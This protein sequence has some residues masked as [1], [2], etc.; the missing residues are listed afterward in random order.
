MRMRMNS[1]MKSVA[2]CVL[3]VVASVRATGEVGPWV[4]YPSEGIISNGVGA[5][6]GWRLRV[7]VEDAARRQLAIGANAVDSAY[8]FNE[9]G[10]ICGTETLDL[11]ERITTSEGERWTIV[12]LGSGYPFGNEDTSPKT[13]PIRYF[14]APRELQ[15]LGGTQ[16]FN[17]LPLPSGEKVQLASFDCPVLSSDAVAYFFN[18]DKLDEA[19]LNVPSLTELKERFL[20]GQGINLG[21]SDFSHVKTIGSYQGGWQPLRPSTISTPQD[22]SFP[23]VETIADSAFTSGCFNKISLGINGNTLKSIGSS[24][25]AIGIGWPQSLN[26]VVLGLAEGCTIGAG[27]FATSDWCYLKTVAFL[28]AVPELA[29]GE[30]FGRP[31]QYA[32][33]GVT[34]KKDYALTM[35]F[36]IPPTA[37]WNGVRAAARALTEEESAAFAERFPGTRAPDGVVPASVFHT[38]TDQ[39]LLTLTEEEVCARTGV[40]LTLSAHGP[41]DITVNGAPGA[42]DFV[43]ETSRVYPYGTTATLVATP[44]R[45][46]FIGWEVLPPGATVDGVTVQATLTA[47]AVARAAFATD[48]VFDSAAKT[49]TDG[50]WVLKVKSADAAA[51]TLTLDENAVSLAPGALTDGV[52]DLRGRITDVATGASWTLN[53]FSFGSFK[54]ANSIIHF[55]APTALKSWPGQLFNGVKSLKTLVVRAPELTGDFGRWSWSFFYSSLE[56][57]VLDVPKMTAF[58]PNSQFVNSPLTATDLAEWNLSSVKTIG[59]NDDGSKGALQIAGP[60]PSGTLKLPALQTAGSNAFKNWSRLEKIELGTDGNLVRVGATA[61]ANCA[62]LRTIDFGT[63]TSF[64]CD[65]NAFMLDD[66]TPLNVAEFIWQGA[67]VPPHDTVE[68]VLQGRTAGDNPSDKPVVIRVD[69]EARA[70]GRLI[71]PVNGA[72]AAGARRLADQGEEVAGVYVTE[73]GERI[74]WVLGF[75]LKGLVITI[76]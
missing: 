48:F 21:A 57:V 34:V 11:R 54:S 19:I 14:Y 55:Y 36:C 68:A 58:E 41:G 51:G 27:A 65:A 43:S 1:L 56:R 40:R 75:K 61:F 76:R 29:E 20:T 72:E 35:L 46:T 18:K 50:T 73:A 2:C 8:V 62:A 52:L 23:C 15:R 12:S 5:S 63:S 30:I 22:L 17:K 25:F 70:W 10:D 33:D 28:G 26:E 37:A 4:Y 66:T 38:Y 53:E 60:G 3:G 13:T 49:L 42:E 45:G 44:R 67:A 69:P 71:Q 7:S 9:N 31:N 47:D 6:A 32:E 74:A 39:L 59:N 64:A 16:F 24:A